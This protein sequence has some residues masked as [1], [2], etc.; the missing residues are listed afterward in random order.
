MDILSSMNKIIGATDSIVLP[1]NGPEFIKRK[2]SKDSFF[3][4]QFVAGGRRGGVNNE[5]K[6]PRDI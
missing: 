4:C 2:Q 1:K 6:S 5:T 3:V